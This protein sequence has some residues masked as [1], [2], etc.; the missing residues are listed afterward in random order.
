MLF[1]W[2]IIFLIWFVLII[3]LISIVF[4]NRL[5]VRDFYFS[6][7]SS[8]AIPGD[9]IVF[10]TT[11]DSYYTTHI[12]TA[13]DLTFRPLYSDRK[14]NISGGLVLLTYSIASTE[15]YYR[16]KVMNG[17][18]QLSEGVYRID[19][20]LCYNNVNFSVDE[21]DDRKI[22]FQIQKYD[23]KTQKSTGKPSTN[24]IRLVKGWSYYY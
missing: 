8:S 23:I 6:P 3:L 15:E 21:G 22:T 7:K 18:K 9:P 4:Y 5:R 10:T 11:T 2:L 12:T 17:T 14:R 13:G 1:D 24:I 20:K 19:P 16:I